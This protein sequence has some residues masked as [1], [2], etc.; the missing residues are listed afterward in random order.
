M[1]D[2]F[3][4]RYRMT[5]RRF[6]DMAAHP[7]RKVPLPLAWILLLVLALSVA[8]Y[9]ATAADALGT[10]AFLLLAAGC[11]F[12][13][14]FYASFRAQFR[15]RSLARVQGAEEWERVVRIAD[16][17][18][19]Q[20]GAVEAVYGWDRVAELKAVPGYLVLLLKGPELIRLD[21][22]GFTAGTAEEFIDHV[23][24]SHP[25]IRIDLTGS[26]SR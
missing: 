25:E 13:I 4:N 24:A 17:I 9:S 20:D 18:V 12:R 5:R 11:A 16:G 1:D 7:V 14:F 2:L 22:D 26:G 23:R 3:E 19:A 15:F 6:L 8:F 10:A 21:R